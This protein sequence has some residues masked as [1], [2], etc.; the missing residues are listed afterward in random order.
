MGC[1]IHSFAEVKTKGNWKKVVEHFSLDDYDKKYYK[2]DKGNNPFDWRSYAMFSFLADV[3][4]R[5]VLKPI[6]KPKGLP[7]NLSEEVKNEYEYWKEEG[8]AASYLTL[9]E[10]LDFDYNKKTIEND[11]YKNVL[12]EWFFKHLEEL[13]LLGE[14]ES[15]RIVFWFDN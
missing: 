12:G 10:L 6:A 4:N 14:S 11:T 7:D 2:K 15:V 3:K 8:F 1:D 5:G 9:K 13:K